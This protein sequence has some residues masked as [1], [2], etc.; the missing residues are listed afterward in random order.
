MTVSRWQTASPGA[1]AKIAG[2]LAGRNQGK[3]ADGQVELP[4]ELANGPIAGL[5]NGG[6][7]LTGLFVGQALGPGPCHAIEVG[8]RD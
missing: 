6:G 1:M 8:A 7:K 2:W 3:H 5:Q 4:G